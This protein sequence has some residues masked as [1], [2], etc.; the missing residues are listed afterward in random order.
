[1]LSSGNNVVKKPAFHARVPGI[2]SLLHS[3][4]RLPAVTLS[5][6]GVSGDSRSGVCATHMSDSS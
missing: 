5:S 2:K 3:Q 6:E 1:M 4:F